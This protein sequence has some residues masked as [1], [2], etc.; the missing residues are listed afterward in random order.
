MAYNTIQT[1]NKLEIAFLKKRLS[2][3]LCGRR[4]GKEM[5]GVKSIGVIYKLGP[6]CTPSMK[7]Q[8]ISVLE[9]LSKNDF[10]AEGYRDLDL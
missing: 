3:H 9:L 4:G 5:M 7:F 8:G 2:P 10:S 1:V 6:T